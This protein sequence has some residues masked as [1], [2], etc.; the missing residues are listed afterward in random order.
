VLSWGGAFLLC[1]RA[2]RKRHLW[3]KRGA[4]PKDQKGNFWGA[5]GKTVLLGD[6]W[7][8]K[9]RGTHPLAGRARVR[10]SAHWA[11][12]RVYQQRGSY[13]SEG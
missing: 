5:M 13:P 10:P 9:E 4:R 7:E 1:G 3:G 6:G 12:K 2:R 8:E 11:E